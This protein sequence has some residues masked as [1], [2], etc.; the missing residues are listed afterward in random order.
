[1]SAPHGD[2]AAAAKTRR[3]VLVQAQPVVGD[4]EANLSALEQRLAAD[5]DADLMV[6]PEL[7]LAGYSTRDVGRFALDLDDPAIARIKTAARD[8]ATAVI[9]GFAERGGQGVANSALCVDEHGA[10]VDC[11]RKVQLFD[12]ERK[13][14]AAGDRLTV[15]HLAG[16]D[17]GVMICFDLEFPEIA[18][19]LAVAGAETLVTISANMTPFGPDHRLFARARAVENGLNHVYVNQVGQGETFV[20]T[21]GSCVVDADGDTAAA[22][23]DRAETLV[24][25]IDAREKSRVR[26]DYLSCLPQEWPTVKGG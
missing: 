25:E 20:F 21:G 10:V 2:K 9:V 8:A 22:H 11:Y 15:A 18:R 23:D 12:A 6:F 4:I 19:K 16:V 24:V 7:Y 13:V 26:P 5:T 17:I 3:V 14:F 1:M